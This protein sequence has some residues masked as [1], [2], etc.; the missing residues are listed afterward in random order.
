MEI[1]LSDTMIGVV[2]ASVVIAFFMILTVL[3]IC[4]SYI[5]D[6]RE[7]KELEEIAERAVRRRKKQLKEERQRRQNG[8]FQNGSSQIFS[9]T[10]ENRKYN[11]SYSVGNIHTAASKKV[12][13][14]QSYRKNK[15]MQAKLKR[16]SMG[17]VRENGASNIT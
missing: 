7:M 11:K 14:F 1:H 2:M 9:I 12:K 6:K 16:K 3:C 13:H 5:D 17:Q 15:M 8:S 10:N 4:G